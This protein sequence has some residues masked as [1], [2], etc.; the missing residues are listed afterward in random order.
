MVRV[1]I[2]G[3]TNLAD[4]RAAIDLGADAVGFLIGKL[5]PSRSVFITAE[6]AAAIVAKLPP[7][8]A[9]VLVTHLTSPQE[10]IQT[11]KI[12]RVNTIQLHGDST[13]EEA[14]MIRAQLPNLKIYVAVHV[15]HNATTRD[16]REFQNSV[17]GI[18]LDTAI[19]ESGQ[20]G[21]T[22]RTHDWTVSKHVVETTALPVILA[23]GLT[24]ENVSQA[25]QFVAP[26]AVDANS[27][28]TNPDGTKDRVRMKRFIDA[29]KAD[30]LGRGN[31]SSV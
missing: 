16:P 1:K 9:C 20:V 12:A 11:A 7:F 23:G 25:I 3:I 28:V 17:D 10:I 24:P 26:Y 18:V 22:G 14:S 30:R 29:A 15:V 5:H 31:A 2:C 6:A 21:G 27:G 8:C 13:P 19:R 4:A